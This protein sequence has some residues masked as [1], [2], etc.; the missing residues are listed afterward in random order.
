MLPSLILRGASPLGLPSTVARSALPRLAPLRWLASLRS[1]ARSGASPLGLPYTVARSALPRLAPLRWLASLRSLASACELPLFD[2][3][4]FEFCDERL[5]ADLQELG[6]APFVA[7]G[8]AHRR[9]D[10]HLF[11]VPCDAARRRGERPGQIDLLPRR[12]GRLALQ[13]RRERQVQMAR[14]ERLAFG[15]DHRALDAVLQLAHVPGPAVR[16]QLLERLGCDHERFLLQIA[17]EAI[18]E[19]PR[20]HRNVAGPLAQ[21]RHGDRKH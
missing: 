13:R 1:L 8:L 14:E 19:V 16:L 6:R 20:Q 17:A 21:R 15:E 11:D 4:L 5:V 7:L 10:L 18:H 2:A 12:Y 3:V 9:F